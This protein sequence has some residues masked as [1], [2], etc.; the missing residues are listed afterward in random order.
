MRRHRLNVETCVVRKMRVYRR[1]VQCGAPAEMSWQ[2]SKNN[3]RAIDAT[4]CR[5]HLRKKKSDV[6]KR[7]HFMC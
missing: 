3:L 2:G 5:D 6:F 7:T 1:R 4:A